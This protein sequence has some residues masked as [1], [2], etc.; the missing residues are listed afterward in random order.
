MVTGDDRRIELSV[1]DYGQIRALHEWLDRVP[2]VSVQRVAGVPSGGQLGAQDILI[3]I[4][5]SGGLIAAIHVIPEFLKARRS[6]ITITVTANGKK[7]SVASSNV[8]DVIP[9]LERTLNER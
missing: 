2:E 7:F 8:K 3:A 9:I 6:N 4:A 5:S 1:S